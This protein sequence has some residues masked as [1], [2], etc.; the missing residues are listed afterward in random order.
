MLEVRKL[1][2]NVFDIGTSGK[3]VCVI[4]K[5]SLTWSVS[6]YDNLNFLKQ[7]V[8]TNVIASEGLLYPIL[9]I[10]VNATLVAVH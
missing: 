7:Y 10:N 3:H 2:R 8:I 5:G 6:D 1:T 9:C 4:T